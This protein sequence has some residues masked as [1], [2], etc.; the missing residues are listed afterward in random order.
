MHRKIKQN[1]KII[2]LVELIYSY[3]NFTLEKGDISISKH[4]KIKTMRS[5]FSLLTFLFLFSLPAILQAQFISKKIVIGDTTQ[6]HV[7]N[8]ENGDRYV[9]RVT[10]IE[11]T[12]VSFLFKKIKKLEF[13]LMEIRSIVLYEEQVYKA[14]DE[15]LANMNSDYKRARAEYY[16]R[17]KDRSRNAI[18]NG[19][20]NL[21]FSPTSYTLG[22]GKKEYQNIMVFYNKLD[23]GLTDNIDIGFDLM[24]LIT[25]NIFA[26]RL[27]A[28]VPV[29]DFVNI[30]FGASTYLTIQPN[31]FRRNVQGT[32]HTYGTATFGNRDKFI[33]VGYGYAFPFRPEMQGVEG[34]SLLTFGG[35]LRIGKRWKVM[36]DFILLGIEREPDFYS[37]GAS[38]FND[39]NRFDF[40]LNVIAVP[41][42]SFI[43]PAIP[44]PFIS[45]ARSFGG[46]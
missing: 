38:W 32:T 29:A 12:S 5:K 9:G 16:S 14:E 34:S 40:G 8:T 22:K 33:N 36:V 15:E 46:E 23:I 25:S 37:F 27:K 28:G 4:T 1:I 13:S 35:A 6:V 7:L 2:N 19:E 26:L 42:N 20:E 45:Y 11:N 10:K 44:I 24:P 41:D 39:R 3:C 30:G 18:L 17:N 43:G 31:G 21:F